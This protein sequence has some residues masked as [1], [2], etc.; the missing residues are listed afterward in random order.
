MARP[1]LPEKLAAVTGADKRSP[2]R[3]K[4]RSAPK[5]APLGA[6][7]KGFDAAQKRAW[8]AFADEMPWLA[9]SDRMVVEVASRL[10][11]AMQTEP[12]FPMGGYAQLR[13]CLSSM[14]GTPADRTKV[15]APDDEDEDPAAAFF[16]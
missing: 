9:K 11:A 8:E 6:P 13:M 2:G 7:P 1:R 4:G 15:A 3:F 14:G 10:R 5:V 12:Q 16:N